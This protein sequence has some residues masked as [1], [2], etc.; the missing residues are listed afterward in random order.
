MD[1]TVAACQMAIE[2]LD[3]SANRRTVESRLAALPEEVDFACFPEYALTGFVPD[4]RV[5][6]AAIHRNGE[7]VAR[8]REAASRAGCDVLV[9]FLERAEPSGELYNAAAYLGSE[10]SMTVYRKRHLW[11][12]EVDYLSAGDRLVTVE[13]PLGTAGIATCYDLNFVA[14]SAAFT[15]RGVDALLVAGAWPEAHGD[16]WR[17]LL[18]AR[19]LDGVRWAVGV[20]RTGWR[21]V[22]DAPDAE[23]AGRSLLARPDGSVRA[24]LDTAERDLVVE[25]DTAAVKR[26][27][28]LIGIY[29][30]QG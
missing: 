25:L 2:D 10:G 26:H 24:A 6:D 29:E 13:T 21:E 19:A 8:I 16:N 15:D 14:D 30:E 3:V 7:T 9:G 27:R 5:A 23:Y 17:F 28:E 18:R 20:G 1:V 4:D 11:A 22:P 12:G